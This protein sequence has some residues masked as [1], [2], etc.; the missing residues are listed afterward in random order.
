MENAAALAEAAAPED[1]DTFW[2]AEYRR[3]LVSRALE[4]MRAEF[5]PTTWRACWEFAVN[6]KPAAQVAAELG[7]SEE[8]GHVLHRADGHPLAEWP[9]LICRGYKGLTPATAD[10]RH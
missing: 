2:E 7:I 8:A 9:L 3:R 4:V 5:Q 1:P 6:D 10:A